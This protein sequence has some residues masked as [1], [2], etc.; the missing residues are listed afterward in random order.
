LNPGLVSGYPFLQP[1][2]GWLFVG[3][4]FWFCLGLV[5]GFNHTHLQNTLDRIKWWLV[6]IL[7]VVFFLGIV[8]WEY[9]LQNSGVDWI[10]PRMTLIDALYILLFLM[11]FLAMEKVALPF[12]SQFDELGARSYGIYLVHSLVLIV[13]AKLSYHFV[14][15]ILGY[16]IV[17]QP[18][19]VISGITV[20]LILMEFIYRSPLRPYYEYL[21]G[22]R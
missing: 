5:V 2:P 14:P 11:A 12:S 21:F 20:P 7:V 6:A 22:R 1:V 9:L 19:L 8:E 16:Q 13:I 17:F 15:L 3:H 18:L 10:G 4:M